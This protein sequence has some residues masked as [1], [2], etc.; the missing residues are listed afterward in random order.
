M[1]AVLKWYAVVFG[2]VG[3]LGLFLTLIYW[4][5]PWSL[6]A[7]CVISLFGILEILRRDW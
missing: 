6:I 7:L 2:I 3:G 4:L 1:M 5:R